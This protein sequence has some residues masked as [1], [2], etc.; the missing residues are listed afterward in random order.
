M[1]SSFAAGP[2]V[3][4]P[5]DVPATRCARSAYNYAHQLARRHGLRLVDVSCSGATTRHVLG[6]WDELPPQLDAVDADTKLVTITIGGNDLGYIGG[7]MAASCLGQAVD[8]SAQASCRPLSPP[9]SDATYAETES[10]MD[11]IA[12]EVRRRAPA[13]QLVF[14]DYMTLLPAGRLCALTPLPEQQASQSRA[15]AAR[16]SAL[17]ARVAQRN[18]ARLLRASALTVGHDACAVTPW[19]NGM[20]AGSTQNGAG[21]QTAAVV[22]Y[23]P[24]LAGMT[25]VA[26]ALDKLLW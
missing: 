6:A 9:P 17:T 13:A 16:L 5:A 21:A 22:P 8:A 25:A 2:G 4:A 1:G 26:D 24:N 12:A 11:R 3:G 19:V 14:V 20:P 7:L 10:R 23:H 15:L 18:G